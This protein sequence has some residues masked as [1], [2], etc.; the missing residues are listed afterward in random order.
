MITNEKKLLL[1][2]SLI[3]FVFV[4]MISFASSNSAGW[5]MNPSTDT[6]VEGNVHYTLDGSPAC[7]AEILVICEDSKHLRRSLEETANCDTNGNYRVVFNSAEE[8]DEDDIVTVRA[9]K[10]TLSNTNTGLVRSFYAR[11]IDVELNNGYPPV[12]PE[13]STVVGIL[14]AL[15]AL[16]MF[17]IVRRK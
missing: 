10:D 14:T 16:G 3:G 17:F 4:S 8:C 13:F 12:I 11:P 1:S 7:D 9:S 5:A 15:F 6:I 2:L